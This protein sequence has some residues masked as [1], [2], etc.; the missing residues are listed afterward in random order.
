MF[1]KIHIAIDC[2]TEEEYRAVQK[3]AEEISSVMRLSAKEFIAVYPEIKKRYGV[4][5]MAKDAIKKNGRK[6]LLPVVGQILSKI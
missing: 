3:I 2:S 4:I 5:S 1:R 6:G